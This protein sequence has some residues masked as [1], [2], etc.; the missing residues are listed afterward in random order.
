MGGELFFAA[1]GLIVMDSR[2]LALK[3]SEAEHDVW[4]IPGGRMEFGETLTETLI[5]EVREETSL[6]VRPEKL[7]AHWDLMGKTRQISGVVFRCTIE[8]GDI[9]LSDEHQDFAWFTVNDADRLY[10]QFAAIVQDLDR[11]L[12]RSN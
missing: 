4:E 10:P 11:E 7:I 12:L 6:L 5:R 2:F 1:K 3:R 9:A 8:T